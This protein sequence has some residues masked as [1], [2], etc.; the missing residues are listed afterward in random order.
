MATDY[1]AGFATI[2]LKDAG[3]S[4]AYIFTVGDVIKN[5]RTGEN[6]LVLTI[7]SANSITVTPAYGSTASAAGLAGDGIFIVGNANAEGSSFRNVNSTR[8]VKAGNMTQ[9]FK[10]TFAVTGTEK[11]LPLYGGKELPYQRAKKG[12]E[13]NLDRIMSPMPVMA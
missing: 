1:T 2:V 7:A 9:I 10:T 13:H 8:A 3:V 5:A 6:M 11:D 12:T 4:P